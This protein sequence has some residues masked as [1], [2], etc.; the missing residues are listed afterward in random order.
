MTVHT[1]SRPRS[2]RDEIAAVLADT[3]PSDITDLADK[4]YELHE[5]SVSPLRSQVAA[6]SAEATRAHAQG[7]Q[8]HYLLAQA[9]SLA[10]TVTQQVTRH[11]AVL[12][13]QQEVLR[14]VRLL[15]QSSFEGRVS[16]DD[17][18]A[19]V[20]E[21]ITPPQCHSTP[22]GFYASEQFRAGLFVSHDGA[23]RVT[24]T[25]VGWQSVAMHVGGGISV[26]PVF[27]VA[28]R[29]ALPAS[30]IEVERGLRLEMPLL[31]PLSAV[32]A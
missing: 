14:K 2:F 18:A 26:E 8:A 28:D 9:D 19:L 12:A 22:L 1:L 15:A 7:K 11:A 4:L 5:A 23:V 32:G 21:E 29:G 3:D 20:T 31:P 25:F 10:A 30:T 27:L 16:A 13:H 24:Y 17:L 6:L